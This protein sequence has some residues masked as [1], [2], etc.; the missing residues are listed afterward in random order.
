MFSSCLEEEQM[1]FSP[2][3]FFH[4]CLSLSSLPVV[5]SSVHAGSEMPEGRGREE[6]ERE[7]PNEREGTGAL[8]R[9]GKEVNRVDRDIFEKYQVT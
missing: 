9:S 7:V 2:S 8:K 1:F 5:S 3:P 6:R 4:L